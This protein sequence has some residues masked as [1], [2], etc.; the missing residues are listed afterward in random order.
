[1]NEICLRELL[2]AVQEGG[3]GMDEAVAR[4][5]RLPVEESDIARLDHHRCLRT[6]LPEIVFGQGKTA[7]QLIHILKAFLKEKNIAFATR[8]AADKAA[9]VRK[10]LPSLEY[11]AE[12]EILI[13]NREYMPSDAGQGRILVLTA[14]TSD[15]PVAE[16]ARLTLEL[17]GHDAAPLYDVGVAGIHRL[18]VHGA[19]LQEAAVIVVAAGM[20][21]ALPSVVAGM[22][23]APVIAVPTSIGYGAGAGGYAALLAMLNSCAPGIAV[24]NIDNGFGA[25]CMAAAINRRSCST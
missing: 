4:L 22:T 11:H 10:V 12:A 5:R 21:G 3:M 8:V 16:E 13:G 6:G 2:A 25:A 19:A 15:I 7:E 18:L 24:V 9:L 14:G 17:L 23:P 20:E 1:M